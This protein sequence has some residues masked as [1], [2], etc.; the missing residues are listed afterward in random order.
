MLVIFPKAFSQVATSQVTIFQVATSQMCNFP[1][2][3]FPSL[4]NAFWGTTISLQR[5]G[6]LS[7]WQ[8][9]MYFQAFKNANLQNQVKILKKPLAKLPK[10]RVVEMQKYLLRVKMPKMKQND[11]S[12]NYLSFANI[13]LWNRYSCTFIILKLI[14]FNLWFI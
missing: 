6:D 4:D 11:L 7:L 13:K 3:N 9:L 8:N 5:Y 14:I 10:T 1:S 2:G 12:H